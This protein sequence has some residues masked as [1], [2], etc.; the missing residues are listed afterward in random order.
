MSTPNRLD[1]RVLPAFLALLAACGAEATP[2][3]ALGPGPVITVSRTVYHWGQ[4][5]AIT[6]VLQNPEGV[7]LYYAGCPTYRLERFDGRWTDSPLPLGW[8]TG[9]VACEPRELAVG[10]TQ[11][12]SVPLTNDS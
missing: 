3:A 2:P 10:A 5:S 4:D 6:V 11:S 9:Q 1:D 12:Y 8:Q 7:P